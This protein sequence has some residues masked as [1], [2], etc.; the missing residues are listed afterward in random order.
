MPLETIASRRARRRAVRAALVVAALAMIVLSGCSAAGLIRATPAA[1]PTAEARAT[2]VRPTPRP[3]ASPPTD[4]GQPVIERVTLATQVEPNGAPKE[5]RSVIPEQPGQ[6]FLCVEASQLQPNTAFR[7]IWF[8]NGQIIGQSDA[9]APA[10]GSDARWVALGY[11]PVFPL[12][13]SVDHAVELLVNQTSIDRYAFRVGV[14]DAKQVI[15]QA[16]LAL[17][18]DADAA[19][20]GAGQRFHVDAQQIVLWARVSNEV[21]PTGMTFATS[22]YRDDTRIAELGPDGGQP[23]VPPTPTPASRRMTFTYVPPARLTPGS[24]RVELYLNGQ[25]V[26][27]YPFTVTAE[28]PAT[29]TAPPTATPRRATPAPTATPDRD[30][31]RVLNLVVANDINADNQAPLGDPVFTLAAQPAALVK[32]WIAV[33]VAELT[34]DDKLELVI[35]RN[36]ADYGTREFKP[37]QLKNGWL[38]EQVELDTPPADE[39]AYTYTVSVYLNGER[40][41]DTTFVVTLANTP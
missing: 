20:V 23:R 21:D 28:L 37:V 38:A 22:W 15:A 25:P 41:L 12:N 26:A 24:Y 16:T 13:P 34:K 35:T 1:S 29:P 9:V 36:D 30:A 4:A 7:A 31:A 32:P 10:A 39:Q 27:T 5:E 33:N 19:P 14:G 11:R 40:T 3:F 8:E 17:G 6:V 18:T 2:A